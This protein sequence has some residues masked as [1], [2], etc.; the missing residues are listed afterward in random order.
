[1]LKL[2]ILAQNIINS[3]FCLF[4]FVTNFFFH[5]FVS[6]NALTSS[7]KVKISNTNDIKTSFKKKNNEHNF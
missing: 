4:D 3:F 6:L 7:L 2:S 5:P 1:M